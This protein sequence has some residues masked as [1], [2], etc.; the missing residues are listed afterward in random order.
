MAQ[1]ITEIEAPR[2]DLRH[3]S[4][5]DHC[6]A[7]REHGDL[8]FWWYLGKS[9]LLG[10]FS[11][12]FPDA[13]GN[14]WYQ[15]KP[16]LCWAVDCF[17]PLDPG[18]VRL[19]LR[20]SLLGYQHVT[21]SEEQ[22]NSH[23]VINAILDLNSYGARSINA[24][25]RNAIRKGY[26]SCTFEVLAEYEPE[27]FAQ[28][29]RAWNELTA[30][31]GWKHAADAD[32]FD[33][34]W[35]RLLGCPGVTIIVG[36]DRESGE[37]A[38]FLV[39]KTIGD[40]AYVDTIASR[41]ELLGTNVNDGIMYAFLMNAKR[42]PGVGKAHYAIRS[43]VEQLEKFKTGLGFTPV[44]FPAHTHLRGLTAPVL[45]RCFP[46]KYHRMIGRFDED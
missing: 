25:R 15:V 35:R 7:L 43:Y 5:R 6:A 45:K 11:L 28:C 16:G 40:T 41:T 2:L 34:S 4:V 46:D 31:T 24:K 36:R 26:R 10:N 44:P 30:R 18:Q 33:G 23:L 3:C 32:S 29:R 27:T 42:L 20:R 14:W 12:P 37:V 38:G 17:A 19:P 39:T 13:D 1:Q 9:R 21:A 22:A 8:S